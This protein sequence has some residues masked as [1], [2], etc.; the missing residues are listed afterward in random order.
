MTDPRRILAA[1]ALAA[2][3]VLT[4][5]WS[6]GSCFN[7]TATGGSVYPPDPTPTPSPTPTPAPCFPSGASCATNAEC[8]GAAAG[9]TGACAVDPATGLGTCR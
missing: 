4:G 8:C 1:V 5:G 6:I 2:A 3:A 7:P 9:Q